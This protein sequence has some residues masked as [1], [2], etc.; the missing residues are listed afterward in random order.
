MTNLCPICE[1]VESGT[2]RYPNAICEY[3]IKNTPPV[4][5]DGNPIDFGNESI[6]GGFVSYVKL[7]NGNTITG[8][9]HHC[10]VN[11]VMCYAKE[12]R[13]G[14]IVIEKKIIN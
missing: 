13:F 9:E 12:H 4:S 8:E 2:S 5:L 3:C 10:F 7:P 11:G 1:E 14:G 6:S